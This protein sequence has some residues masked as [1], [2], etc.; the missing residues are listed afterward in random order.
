[1]PPLKDFPE[2]AESEKE[3]VRSGSEDEDPTEKHQREERL[4]DIKFAIMEFPGMYEA[5]ERAY[6]ALSEPRKGYEDEV[7]PPEPSLEDVKTEDKEGKEGKEGKEEKPQQQHEEPS[8]DYFRMTEQSIKENFHKIF[9]VNCDIFAR[10]LYLHLERN[11]QKSVL[12]FADF[13]EAILPLHDEN[14]ETRSQWIFK[15]YDMD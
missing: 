14:R 1:M 13:A 3:S 15:I 7:N 4:K 9:E 11:C 5:I 6:R 8:V 2:W 10:I 12:E